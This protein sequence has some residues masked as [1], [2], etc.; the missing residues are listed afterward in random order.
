MST[1]LS[2][3]E[4]PEAIV[5]EKSKLSL[6][7]LIPLIAL[8]IGSWLVYT[9]Q[10]NKGPDI[11]ISFSNAEGLETGKTRVKYK[12]VEVGKVRDIQLSSDLKTVNVSVRLTRSA[13]EHLTGQAR[14][15][16]VRPRI[17]GS[18]VSGLNTL[19]SGVHIGM[20]PGEGENTVLDQYTGLDE[21][22]FLESEKQ[23][24]PY[25]L[26][27]ESLASLD[28]GSPIYYRQ[29]EV[30]EV[31]EYE[32]VESGRTVNISIFIY[33]PYDQLV[34][35]NSRFWNASGFNLSLDSQGVTAKLE[36][37]AALMSG[38]ISFD[39]PL[40]LEAAPPSEDY[41]SFVLYPDF[42]STAERLYNYTL[43]YVMHFDGSL[44]GLSPGAPVEYRGIKVG[45]VK[46]IKI[47]MDNDTY[48]VSIP[49]LVAF[50]P[51]R[52]SF[53]ESGSNHPQEA[54]EALVEKG[55]RA[56]LEP[57]N[58]L[59][60][61]M[62]VDLDFFP[63]ESPASI[64]A[65]G[66]YPEFPTVEATLDTIERSFTEMVSKIEQMPLVEIT[67][68]LNK[69]I[70]GLN[71]IVSAPES[72]SAIKNLDKALSGIETLTSKANTRADPILAELLSSLTNL[73][74][75]LD[76]AQRTIAEDSMLYHDVTI[77]VNELSDAA[78]SIKD[79]SDYLQR[80]PD[81]LIFGKDNLS[82]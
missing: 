59:T 76:T 78:R 75:T 23:G 65:N 32:L 11:V 22:P 28:I 62:Y 14:F 12:D 4:L 3:E 43:F 38:G 60:G 69:T 71:K 72:I 80:R 74:S 52:I 15:W 21:P 13:G 63:D 10:R 27:A 29:I 55:L 68:N 81:A 7:W 64:Q 8:L 39:T 51:E 57:G 53:S 58:L 73:S 41:D 5:S 26:T 45:E 47:S 31:T 77:M 1:E 50:Q 82:R 49:V 79:F 54:I 66:R 16:V 48:D 34:R 61:Q 42:A 37:L 18:G 19:I 56:Q 67:E 30:G 25:T 33:F 46:D 40:N 24:T 44:R 70:V 20:D 2:S 17:S 9:A 36:S 6:V 35:R